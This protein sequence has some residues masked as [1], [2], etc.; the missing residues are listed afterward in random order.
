MKKI[1][2]WAAEIFC[3]LLEKLVDRNSY[4]KLE[5]PSFEP[6]Y[7]ERIQENLI[8]PFGIGEVYSLMH[9]Y[10]LNGDMMRDPEMCFIVVDRRAHEKEYHRIGIYPQL[11]RQDNIGLYEESILIES[12]EVSTILYKTQHEHVAF[13]N[14][15]LNN[16]SDQG[17]L[18]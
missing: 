9:T 2:N 10:T 3:R 6:L 7:L 16:I 11:F 1:N 15:W 17:Y 14:D 12:D 13:A 18:D 8:T 4:L 5:L